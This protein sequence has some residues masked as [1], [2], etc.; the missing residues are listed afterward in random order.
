M[1]TGI[2]QEKLAC[3]NQKTSGAA[4]HDT[5]VLKTFRLETLLPKSRVGHTHCQVCVSVPHVPSS[6]LTALACDR[7]YGHVTFKWRCDNSATFFRLIP[8]ICLKRRPSLGLSK[9]GWTVGLYTP[10]GTLQAHTRPACNSQN[11]KGRFT[12]TQTPWGPSRAAPTTLCTY[13]TCFEFFTRTPSSS[14]LSRQP[15]TDSCAQENEPSG[16]TKRGK[17][18]YLTRD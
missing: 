18:I 12:P 13:Q 8:K 15:M 6:F 14:F 17:F 3:L 5:S 7:I 9:F 4:W 1:T 2:Y 10:A 11:F 16:S